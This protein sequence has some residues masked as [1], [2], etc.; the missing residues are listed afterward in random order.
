MLVV[1]RNKRL[2]H[3]GRLARSQHCYCN[4]CYHEYCAE[5]DTGRIQD[6]V[7]RRCFQLIGVTR[8]G[9]VL[10]MGTLGDELKQRKP[11]RNIREEAILNIWRTGDVLAAR[12]ED[13]LQT[14]DLSRTQYN[15]LRIL[16]GAG[17]DGLPCGEVAARMLTRGPDVTRMLDRLSRRGL[18]RRGRVRED[19]R[20]ILARITP[21]GM[22][23]LTELDAP[24]AKLID[25]ITGH[26]KESQFGTLIKILERLRSR[27]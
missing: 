23:L 25:E 9:T 2:L 14:R 18:A 4:L 20:I 24:V 22:E 8:C 7:S 26:I 27:P 19:R 10:S 3:Q 12:L 15:A 16:R 11:F 1:T 5:P 21:R 13:L 17:R 6:R